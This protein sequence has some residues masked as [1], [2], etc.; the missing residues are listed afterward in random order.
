SCRTHERTHSLPLRVFC[1]V[2]EDS[3]RPAVCHRP[4][5]AGRPRSRCCLCSPSREYRRALCWD[6]TTADTNLSHLSQSEC[7]SSLHSKAPCPVL[8]SADPCRRRR[9]S[10]SLSQTVCPSGTAR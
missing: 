7:A 9:P 2:P 8:A 3:V 5:A 4:F 1:L 10:S 6:C